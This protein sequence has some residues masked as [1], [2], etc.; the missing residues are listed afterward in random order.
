MG[1]RGLWQMISHT[2]E[3]KTLLSLAIEHKAQ[4]DAQNNG[5]GDHRLRLGVD[6]GPCIADCIGTT[7]KPGVYN[8]L[9]GV[10][11]VF[12][13]DGPNRPAFKRGHEVCADQKPWWLEDTKDLIRYFG[14]QVHQAPGKGEAELARLNQE[15][16]ID[17]V[18]TSDVDAIVFGANLVLR[19][20]V[21]II[22]I[23]NSI[24]NKEKNFDD[25]YE[26]YTSAALAD[27]GFPHGSFEL[28]ALLS[29]GDYSAGVMDCGPAIAQAMGDAFNK[30]L[31][32]WRVAMQDELR[33]NSLGQM[34]SHQPH[35][36]DNILDDFPD[37]EVL[38]LYLCPATSWS[39]PP[40][41][42]A[43]DTTS[44]MSREVSIFNLAQFCQ[45]LS[46]FD[47][48][49][50]SIWTPTAHVEIL[51]ASMEV[52]RDRYASTVND[53]RQPK[54]TVSTSNL[55]S[56][57]SSNFIGKDTDVIKMWVPAPLLPPNLLV[58]GPASRT[59]GTSASHSGQKTNRICKH[60]SGGT[61]KA[62]LPQKR[63]QKHL[64][65]N[66]KGEGPSTQTLD[67]LVSEVIEIES[68]DDNDDAAD[69]GDL[70]VDALMADE[71]LHNWLDVGRTTGNQSNR[72]SV[73]DLTLDEGED[74][75]IDLTGDD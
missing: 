34:S 48:S 69:L 44:W 16:Y 35:V 13:F 68:S 60:R 73:I 67:S 64:N 18:I 58:L 36:A 39:E 27:A 28:F 15:G 32:E 22:Q 25:E 41:Y 72:D 74:D 14:F 46:V 9:P 75:I 62:S 4:A 47:A 19:T 10:F 20:S 52:R 38:N 29:G 49:S 31:V 70:K 26:V 40:H 37:R 6:M 3:R 7:R 30:F 5:H 59:G 56:L 54:L 11:L 51:N 24:W 66:P 43:P 50:R 71:E 12:I 2:A 63:C 23:M 53:G 17:G 55:V 8:Q 61:K 33:T 65:Q 1:V 45:P 42:Q 21:V 57:M